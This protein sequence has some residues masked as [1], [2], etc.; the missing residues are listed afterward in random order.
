M[1]PVVVAG[2]MSSCGVRSRFGRRRPL[3]QQQAANDRSAIG[4]DLGLGW[5]SR[6]IL[7]VRWCPVGCDR[8]RKPRRCPETRRHERLE[9]GAQPLAVGVHEIGERRSRLHRRSHTHDTHLDHFPATAFV[10]QVIDRYTNLL[11]NRHRRCQAMN[12]DF[13]WTSWLAG[14]WLRH[15]AGFGS[16]SSPLGS[17]RVMDSWCRP[18]G[19]GT[20]RPASPRHRRPGSAGRG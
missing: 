5:E 3:S 18:A 19:P 20:S 14:E 7:A 1:P 11:A 2:G 8:S 4:R 13:P 6:P 12:R 10:P 9:L 17:V 15:R 16:S